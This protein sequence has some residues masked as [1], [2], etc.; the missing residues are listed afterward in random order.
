MNSGVSGS[1]HIFVNTAH[2]SSIDYAIVQIPSD[3]PFPLSTPAPLALL[4]WRASGFGD[5]V[6][7][8]DPERPEIRQKRHVHIARRKHIAAKGKQASWNEDGSRHDRSMFDE[9]TGALQVVK[10]I[11]RTVLMLPPD[12]RLELICDV[13]V[14]RLLLCADLPSFSER[15]QDYAS[16]AHFV[17]LRVRRRH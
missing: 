14:P 7:R 5:W 16:D 11:A 2:A 6:Y 8:I 12:F 1:D 13:E 4:G 3:W 17:V 15:A 10:E 9:R